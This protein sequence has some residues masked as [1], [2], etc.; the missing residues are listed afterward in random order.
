MAFHLTSAHPGF[1]AEEDVHN[2]KVSA[3][4]DAFLQQYP[5][6]KTT[7]VLDTLRATDYRRLDEE[8]QVYLDYTG[9]SLHADS[10]VRQHI[11]M[12][13]SH[14]YGNPHSGSPASH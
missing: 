9:G 10:Q 5:D 12:L 2:E 11:E 7:T 14:V 8:Q 1:Q 3:A 6:Y 13:S 4:F